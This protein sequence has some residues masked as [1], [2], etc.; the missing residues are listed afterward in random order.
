MK[1]NYIELEEKTVG[2]IQFAPKEAIANLKRN[3]WWFTDTENYSL[4]RN[5]FKKGE[6]KKYFKN[7][8]DLREDPFEGKILTMGLAPRKSFISC[9][10]I[11]SKDD[12]KEN[13]C[14]KEDYINDILPN[15]EL[16]YK[17]SGLLYI[18]RD[19][20][21]DFIWKLDIVLVNDLNYMPD[22][23]CRPVEYVNLNK[24]IKKANATEEKIKKSGLNLNKPGSLIKGM[25]Y[26][27]IYETALDLITL[28]KPSYFTRQHE[29][30][31][32]INF[33]D[34]HIDQFVK[35]QSKENIKQYFKINDKVS[36][37]RKLKPYN[38]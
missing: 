11:I 38:P 32:G 17:N 8:D 20:V 1:R 36:Y 16:T 7:K 28:Y 6:I 27:S 33:K 22:I 10:S 18:P 5:L 30:R 24:Y 2:L 29:A 35:L 19:S 14:L 26:E 9:F 37:I 31:I 23:Y 13:G 15:G 3:E 4:N 12:I 25:Y 21:R 34:Q